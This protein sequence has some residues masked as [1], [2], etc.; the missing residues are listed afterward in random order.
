MV[1]KKMVLRGTPQY[2]W[3]EIIINIIAIGFLTK[4]IR[5][6]YSL[7]SITH[8]KTYHYLNHIHWHKATV[9]VKPCWKVKVKVA[10]LCHSLR[11]HGPY[12]LW[13]SPGQNTRWVAFPFSKGS[14]QPRDRTQVSRIVGRCFTVWATRE[15]GVFYP[16]EAPHYI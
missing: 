16:S 5:P 8:V 14:S 13:S 15:V 3:K 9:I 7:H 1:G 10:Q 12:S 4:Y 2:M 6:C 11:P